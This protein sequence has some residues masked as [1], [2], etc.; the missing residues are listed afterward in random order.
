MLVASW[1]AGIRSVTGETFPIPGRGQ[2]G[3]L[4]AKLR[5]K[6]GGADPCT[7][8]HALG[9]A[10]ATAK[11]G[12]QLSAAWFLEWIGSGRP[13]R[14]SGIVRAAPRGRAV[15]PEAPPGEETWSPG[16]GLAE[17]K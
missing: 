7:E 17:G 11:R 9:A 15:Q 16:S 10:Y 13:D 12:G 4:A 3:G 5:E 6:C 1:A 14:G 2:Y 8:A